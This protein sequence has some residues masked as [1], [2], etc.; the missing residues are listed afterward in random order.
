MS[1]KKKFVIVTPPYEPNGGGATALYYLCYLLNKQGHEAKVFLLFGD[2]PIGI[3]FFLRQFRYYMCRVGVSILDR[4]TRKANLL[5]AEKWARYRVSPFSNPTKVIP[6]V[7]DT[8]IVIYPEIVNGNPLKAFNVVRW[9]LYKPGGHT[10]KINY[11]EKDLFFCYQKVFNDTN[12]NPDEKTLSI[13]YIKKDIY[14]QT[15]FGLRQGRCYIVRKGRGRK[16]LP[17]FFDGPIIDSLTDEKIAKIFNQCEYCISYDQ[18]TMYSWYA[19][20]CGCISVVMPLPGVEKEEWQPKQENRYA[21]A[22]GLDPEEVQ[23]A[24][25]TK[26]DLNKY[27]QKLEMENNEQVKNFVSLCSKHFN[28]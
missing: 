4:F 16:D 7:K 25:K 8:T 5:N 10:G 23:Y 28:N 13:T 20:M 2:K 18:Y 1:S 14:K 9:L 21:T 6:Y 17:N 24:Q 26:V 3:L 11:G 15:N 27:L 22:Y 12:L 19:T